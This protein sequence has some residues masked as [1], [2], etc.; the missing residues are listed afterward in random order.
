MRGIAGIGVYTYICSTW[1]RSLIQ[2]AIIWVSLLNPDIQSSE[3][4]S[5]IATPGSKCGQVHEFP[6]EL[7]TFASLI[8]HD[9]Q[10]FLFRDPARTSSFCIMSFKNRKHS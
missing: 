8:Q 3:L 4:L 7:Q 9:I 2:C 1:I 5:L 10:E 6:D